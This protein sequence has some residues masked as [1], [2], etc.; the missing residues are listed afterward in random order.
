MKHKPR[1]DRS[2]LSFGTIHKPTGGRI[3]ALI[4]F[5]W[6]MGDVLCAERLPQ[7]ISCS[8]WR[9]SHTEKP[10]R[11]GLIS[12]VTYGVPCQNTHELT[13]TAHTHT[14]SSLYLFLSY[15][16]L[17]FVCNALVVLAHVCTGS[18]FYSWLGARLRPILF[19]VTCP[20][21]GCV[22]LLSFGCL[23]VCFA[24][25]IGCC[26]QHITYTHTHTHASLSLGHTHRAAANDYCRSLLID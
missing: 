20:L 8:L 14:F 13:H 9:Q 10:D 11:T 17:C 22:V 7:H 2:D 1:M 25:C 24:A 19:S 15:S 18:R 3:G 5:T 23:N 16:A 4:V 6:W 12:A 26:V 21:T